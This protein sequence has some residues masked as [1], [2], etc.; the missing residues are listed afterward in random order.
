MR[1]SRILCGWWTKALLIAAILLLITYATVAFTLVRGAAAQRMTPIISAYRAAFNASGSDYDSAWGKADD[2]VANLSRD[3]SKASDEAS[4]ALLCYY[5]GSHTTEDMLE[6][7]ASRGLRVLP[8]IEKYQKRRP[9]LLRFDLDFMLQD[10]SSCH[11]FLGEAAKQIKHTK[12]QSS[13]H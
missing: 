11:F 5:L 12:E 6:N 9:V 7:V 8:Y 1:Y 10:S 13:A 2:L 4:V 3:Q